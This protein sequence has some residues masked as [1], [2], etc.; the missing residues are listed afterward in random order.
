MWEYRHMV[1]ASQLGVGP[2]VYKAWC[3]RHAIGK[4]PSGLYAIT[5]R[6]SHDLEEAL[7][8][9]EELRASLSS[10]RPSIENAISRCVDTLAREGIFV[11]DLKPSNVVVQFGKKEE[12]V[13]VKII[14]FGR[15]FCEWSGCESDPD[16]NT[17]CVTMLRKR[18]LSLHPSM[19]EEDRSFLL[20]HILYA[21]MMV[22]L[23]ATTTRILHEDRACHRMDAKTREEVHPTLSVTRTLLSNM[24]GRNVS[25]LRTL[26]RMDDV[27]GVLRHYNGRRDAGTRRTLALARGKG[28]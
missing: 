12:D 23:T 7:C 11:Y 13:T 8:R 22:L 21:G 6:F 9:D 10:R 27:K 1:K 25:L 15:D 14:D 4:W 3:S 26:L 17:P 24:Q 16:S 19:S 2:E 18:I 20:S 5:E 28:I